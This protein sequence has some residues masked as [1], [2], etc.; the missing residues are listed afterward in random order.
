MP[1][2][3]A[4]QII[5]NPFIELQQVQSTNSHA[6]DKVKANLAAHGTA[7]FAHQQTAGKGQ[8]SKVWNTEPNSNII[9]SVVLDISFLPLQNRF[10]LSAAAALAAHSFFSHYAGKN[11]KIKW[12]NDL[13]YNDRKA[14]GILIETGNWKNQAGNFAVVGLGIN[15]NQAHFPEHLPNPIS[16][17]QITGKS[18][19]PITLA[20]ELCAF[21]EQRYQQLKN[22]EINLFIDQLNEHLYKRQQE[23]RLK[24]GN[25]AFFCIVESVNSKGELVVSGSAQTNFTFGEVEW[26]VK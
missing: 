17:T 6:I 8:H 22:G 10:L 13:Y 5:G 16:L 21:L 20:K 19:Q 18:Y 15:I 26:V 4:I 2:T 7:Y 24:K 23:V 9:L 12:T 14:G 11:T 25:I 3:P 1:S